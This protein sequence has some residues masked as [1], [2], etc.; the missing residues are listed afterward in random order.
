MIVLSVPSAHAQERVA[1]GSVWHSYVEKLEPNAYVRV[2]LA[3][4]NSLKG[5]IV[6]VR[7]DGFRLNPKTRVAVPVRNLAYGDVASVDVLRE[8]K[9]NP[10]VKVLLGVG[11]GAGSFLLLTVIALINYTD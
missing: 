5:H 3:D 8:P 4:G 2:R 11:V 6:E 9:W 10:A 1:D 7:D